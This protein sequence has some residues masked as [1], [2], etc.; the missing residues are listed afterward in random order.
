VIPPS[1]SVRI[2]APAGHALENA[3]S[4]SWLRLVPDPLVDAVTFGTHKIALVLSR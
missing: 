1:D 3:A 2:L 4:S